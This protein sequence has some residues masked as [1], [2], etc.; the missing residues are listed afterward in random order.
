MEGFRFVDLNQILAKMQ[1]TDEDSVLIEVLSD[2]DDEMNESCLVN[3]GGKQFSLTSSLIEKLHIKENLLKVGSNY[4]LDRDPIYFE[5]IVNESDIDLDDS[6]FVNE[7]YHYG[8][9]PIL[10]VSPSYSIKIQKQIDAELITI[11]TDGGRIVTTKQTI[12]YSPYLLSKLDHDTVRLDDSF[13][14]VRRLINLLRLGDMYS[15]LKLDKYGLKAE[16]VPLID[17]TTVINHVPITSK[18]ANRI[19]II[20][21]SD[22]LQF[23]Q[24]LV[25]DLKQN[26]TIQY[27]TDIILCIDI[28]ASNDYERDI[29]GHIVDHINL[30]MDGANLDLDKQWIYLS[31]KLHK[32]KIHT[33]SENVQLFYNDGFIPVYRIL[34]PV[35][36]L[37][38]SLLP[39]QYLKQCLLNVTMTDRITNIPLL[40]CHLICFPVAANHIADHFFS[41]KVYRS[42]SVPKSNQRYNTI[43]VPLDSFGMMKDL[44]IKARGMIEVTIINPDKSVNSRY[45]SMMMQD[46]FP[47]KYLGRRL[48]GQY[49]YVCFCHDANVNQFTG[50]LIGN[51]YQMQMKV[52]LGVDKIEL[53]CQS[54]MRVSVSS[55]VIRSDGSK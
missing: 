27:L 28:P 49:H 31:E 35:N 36:L 9:Y 43:A 12:S 52:H 26:S 41:S 1:D 18:T 48:S 20:T 45:D 29:V 16:I 14:D 30:F 2:S 25:F 42:I 39:V 23:G 22:P 21:T 10:D 40:N 11:I 38:N 37:G 7:L 32:N 53:F 13:D 4:F 51:G 17:V 24:K 19:E 8:I 33:S 3:V 5:S 55:N 15:D 34:M 46:L 6:D 54:Y 47:S 44:V 50:G